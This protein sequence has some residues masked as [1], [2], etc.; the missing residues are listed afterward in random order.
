[1][2]R[3]IL[4]WALVFAPMLARQC[5]GEVVFVPMAV[6][7]HQNGNGPTLDK[8]DG[9]VNWLTLYVHLILDVHLRLKRLNDEQLLRS[10]LWLLKGSE[11]L[12]NFP[13]PCE[14]NQ[15]QRSYDLEEL[16]P[17]H[18]HIL[19]VQVGECNPSPGIVIS[20]PGIPA[21]GGSPQ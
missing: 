19:A 17:I 11:E 4:V 9:A 2:L 21:N 1:M 13:R 12:Q 6:G 16:P 20:E 8:T 3:M 18:G 5:A 7:T 14:R 10:V 15:N